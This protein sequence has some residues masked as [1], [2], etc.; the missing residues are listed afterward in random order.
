MTNL[1]FHIKKIIHQTLYHPLSIFLCLHTFLWSLIPLLRKSP[2]MDSV[3]AIIWGQT[4]LLGNNKHPPFSGWFISFFHELF[5]KHDIAI[6]FSSQCC[7]FFAFIYTYKIARLFLDKTTALCCVLLLEGCIYYTYTST[8]FNVNVVSLALW[9]I[10]TYYFYRSIHTNKLKHWILLGLFLALNILNKYMCVFLFAG[11]WGYLLF[12]THGRIQFKRIGLYLSIIITLCLITPHLLWLFKTNFYSFQYLQTRAS[13][14]TSYHLI[15]HF[16]SP[17]KFIFTQILAITG[18]IFIFLFIYQRSE[19]KT[20]IS[21]KDQSAF[22]FFI[23]ICPLLLFSSLALLTGNPLKSMWGTPLMFLSSILMFYFFSI[24][25]T[26]TTFVLTRRLA[27]IFMGL[28]LFITILQI[29]LTTSDK[30]QLSRY[31]FIKDITSIWE[32]STHQASLKHIGG[33]IWYSSIISAYHPEHPKNILSGYGTNNP[34]ILEKEVFEDGILLLAS[35]KKRLQEYQ[36]SL[37]SP[38]DIAVYFFE[39]KNWFGKTKKHTLYY[40]IIPP[41]WQYREAL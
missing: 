29:A 25:A 20:F 22:L 4:A 3:E 8:E 37:Y 2:P 36:G 27:Y 10:A 5:Q 41:Q 15:K 34:F 1:L 9:P 38:L 16:Y 35:N 12:T 40:V 32:A 30:Y 13:D 24:K 11:M 17:I 7:I 14:A 31:S 19:K 23:G 21:S 18:S 39:T 28:F 33:D 26:L 6:Y